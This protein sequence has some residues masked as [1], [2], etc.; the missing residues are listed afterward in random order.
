[1][2]TDGNKQR[3]KSTGDDTNELWQN[4]K[5]K[6]PSDRIKF[7][8]VRKNHFI[9]HFPVYFHTFA[10]VNIQYKMTGKRT[11]GIR[12]QSA[13]TIKVTAIRIVSCLCIALFAGYYAGITFFP[14]THIINGV[15]IVHSHI[16]ADSHHDTNSGEHTEQC[17]TLIA[18]ISQ[19]HYVDFLCS[20]VS[21]PLQFQIHEI[22]PVE[23]AHRV[24]SIYLEN[25]LLRAPPVV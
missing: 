7:A 18:A 12:N 15:T 6:G 20:I 2:A 19:L 1:M 21:L 4:R 9:F 13:V 17:I 14:H 10:A 3:P 24:T 22:K 16:H 11:Y 8:K 5:M 23:T 25:T